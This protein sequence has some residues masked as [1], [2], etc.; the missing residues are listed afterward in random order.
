MANYQK[1]ILTIQQQV[2]AF[3]DAG[4]A[5]SDIAGAKNAMETIGY[6]RLRGYCFHKYDNATKKYVPGTDFMEV[7][8]LY[9]FDTELSHLLFSMTSLIEVALRVRLKEA[10]LMYN[11]PLILNDPSAFVN[12]KNFWQ[13]LSTVSLEIARSSD[14][15]IKHNYDNHDGEVPVWAAVEVM[16]FGTLSKIIKNLKAGNGNAYPVLADYYSY[17]T[18]NK[19]MAKPS[20]DTFTSWVQAVSILRNMCAHNSRIYNRAISTT[21]E[22]LAVDRIIPKQRFNGL[23]QVMLAMKYLRPS[24]DAWNT[25]VADFNKLLAQYQGVVELQRMNFPTDWATHFAL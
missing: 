18:A 12:K 21:P 1:K 25:F 13:N 6:Y 22:I 8:R 7:L 11:D 9:E 10:L 17:V 4:M 24:D 2:Q 16:S 23:Y 19:R 5:V 14:V 20:K 3:I 15:F